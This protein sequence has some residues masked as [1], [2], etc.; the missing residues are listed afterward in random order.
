M[1]MEP[2]IVENRSLGYRI[3]YQLESFQ[4]NYDTHYLIYLGYPLFIPLEGGDAKKKHWE[5]NRSLAYYGSIMHFMR[6]V[7]RNNIREEGF[8]VRRLVRVPNSERERVKSLHR[9]NYFT[10][11]RTTGARNT[12]AD[13]SDSGSYYEKILKQPP[14]FDLVGKALLPGDSIA[15]A[16]TTERAGLYFPD[17]LLVVYTKKT[18]PAEYR[19]AFPDQG[20]ARMSRITLVHGQPLEIEANGNYYDPAELLTYGYWAWSEKICIMLPLDY[21]PGKQ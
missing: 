18:A 19:N 17:Y 7:Y 11:N 1:A 12:I 5:K 13:R 10:I 4:Y 14:Y 20:S 6:S 8:E 2:L 15:Y 9:G 16:V 3:E 21:D